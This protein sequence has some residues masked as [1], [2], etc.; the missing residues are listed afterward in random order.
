MK[1]NK[2]WKELRVERD[3][4]RVD[5]AR[6]RRDSVYLG[7]ALVAVLGLYMLSVLSHA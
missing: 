1:R 7:L 4:R 5:I 2:T 6:W 3:Q